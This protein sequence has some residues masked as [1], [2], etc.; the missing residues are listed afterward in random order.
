MKYG[1]NTKIK[2]KKYQHQ[3]HNS[4]IN[5]DGDMGSLMENIVSGH[6]VTPAIFSG[7]KND[8]NFISSELI[9]LDF[10]NVTNLDEVLN[11]EFTVK[12]ATAFYLTPSATAEAI[13]FRLVFN[14][15]KVIQDKEEYKTAVLGLLTLYPEADQSCKDASRCFFGNSNLQE[16]SFK[17][18]FDFN[19]WEIYKN[20]S[21]A[22]VSELLKHGNNARSLEVTRFDRVQYDY[23]RDLDLDLYNV[24]EALSFI[25]SQGDYEDW[26]NIAW[27]CINHFGEG[28]GKA[29]INEWSPDL[30]QKGKHLDD[31]AKKSRKS[32]TLGTVFYI[33]MKFGYTPPLVVSSLIA[34]EVKKNIGELLAGIVNNLDDPAFRGFIAKVPVSLFDEDKEEQEIFKD[35]QAVKS[36]QEALIRIA[37]KNFALKPQ[38]RPFTAD[39]LVGIIQAIL[40]GLVIIGRE[41]VILNGGLSKDYGELIS[42]LSKV[43]KKYRIKDI[44]GEVKEVN[45][46]E[47]HIADLLDF[48]SQED[49]SI[50]TGYTDLDIILQGLPLGGVTVLGGS[51]GSG[52]STLALNIATRIGASNQNPIAFYSYEMKAREHA[53]RTC[54][55][56]CAEDTKKVKENFKD[57]KGV[58][59]YQRALRAIKH[60]NIVHCPSFTVMDIVDHLKEF[61][62]NNPDCRMAIV[63]HLHLVKPAP[64][65][66]NRALVE[67]L[68][69]TTSTLKRI[70]SELDIN[71]ML[72]AQLSRQEKGTAYRNP[73]LSDLRS[74]GT[75]EQDA[76]QVI[77][78]ARNTDPT[79]HAEETGQEK[80][81]Y[82]M[83]GKEVKQTKTKTPKP[84]EPD[85]IVAKNRE[86]GTGVVGFTFIGQTYTFKERDQDIDLRLEELRD[87]FLNA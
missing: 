14:L 36:K 47:E 11:K 39:M 82:K 69:E 79:S 53:L 58:D 62:K 67:Q 24:R 84:S 55:Y 6:A 80:G 45:E 1:L 4:W 16:E 5:Q 15:D 19:V 18:L 20:K 59:K 43:D 31:L 50:K 3:A 37:N 38:T 9:F 8:N 70:A 54:S 61:K 46:P 68:G 30:K 77:L 48:F 42:D 71:I 52:K 23:K 81:N 73:T 28:Q 21:K 72:L 40:D 64:E 76:N 78:I 44:G 66:A 33:A 87:K 34:G 2:D 74:S 65:F 17:S 83:Y 85:I 75:I 60:I 32:H 22:P 35:I 51:T 13:K 12:Y 29:L 57:K 56:L 7:E 49:N 27:G 25:P 10:D 63:D 86:G 41:Q 26:R